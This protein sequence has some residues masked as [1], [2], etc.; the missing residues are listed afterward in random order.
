[1]VCRFGDFAD[2]VG[3]GKRTTKVGDRE[4]AAKF[5]C[6]VRVNDLPVGY[7]GAEFFDFLVGERVFRS[8]AGNALFGMKVFHNGVQNTAGNPPAASAAGTF[9][10]N[11]TFD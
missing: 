5:G 11:T 7:I 4:A 8:A 6:C 3:K 1:M 9:P 2:L 10:V